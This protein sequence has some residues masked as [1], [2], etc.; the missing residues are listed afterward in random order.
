MLLKLNVTWHGLGLKPEPVSW[1]FGLLGLYTGLS[2]NP[3]FL[4]YKER[5][6]SADFVGVL[7]M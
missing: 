6:Y 5:D 7:I 2:P 1:L 4:F 3:G